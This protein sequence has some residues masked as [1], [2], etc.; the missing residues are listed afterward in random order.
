MDGEGRRRN[1]VLCE[2]TL[3]LL[4]LEGATPMWPKFQHFAVLDISCGLDTT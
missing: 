1:A 3:Q 2:L 4:A